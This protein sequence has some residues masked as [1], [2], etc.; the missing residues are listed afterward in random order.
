MA[1]KDFSESSFA[2]LINIAGR[3]RML[4][5]RVGFLSAVLSTACQ[6]SQT[7]DP[8]QL[9]MLRTAAADFRRGYAVL[10]H[11]APDDGLPHW[12]SETVDAVLGGQS[13]TAGG[14]I[15][16]RFMAETEATIDLLSVG[17]SRSEAELSRFSLFVLTDVLRVLQAIV[18]AL[19]SDF[20]QEM[21]KRKNRRLEELGRVTAAIHEIQRASK[22]SR[23]IALNA[24]ISA[25]RAGPHGGEFRALTDE[26]KQISDDITESSDD[27]LRFL[28]IA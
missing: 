10:L 17:R 11:G 3:Q 21:T 28:E 20:E 1:D 12:S 26:I 25:N 9:D 15:V 22:F 2:R 18:S 16:D 23:M 14:K 4:S 24:K 13:A 7:P 27:I 19:E 6:R 5:Q 8:V